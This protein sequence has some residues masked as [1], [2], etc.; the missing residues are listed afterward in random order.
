MPEQE[1][2]PFGR[3]PVPGSAQPRPRSAL[4]VVLVVAG[5]LLLFNTFLTQSQ[6]TTVPF[7][8]FRSAIDSGDL[9]KDEPVTITTTTITGVV[10]D[11]RRATN[12]RGDDPARLRADRSRR[13]SERSG[14]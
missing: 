5:A 8:Q 11:G 10:S 2:K 14:V 1:R 12:V 9:V 6:V 3:R 4:V 7:S 13:R